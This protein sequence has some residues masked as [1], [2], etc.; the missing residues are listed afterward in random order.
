M[1]PSTKRLVD[2]AEFMRRLSANESQFWRLRQSGVVPEPVYLGP[3]SPR[4]PEEIVESVIAR[5]LARGVA[6]VDDARHAMRNV[7]RSGRPRRS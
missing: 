7:T 6:T 2:K 3:K 1:Q 5:I 4:W